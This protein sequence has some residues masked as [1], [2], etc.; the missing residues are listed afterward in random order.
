MPRQR[1]EAEVNLRR[2]GGGIAFQNGAV[3][4]HRIAEDMGMHPG[5]R[6][7]RNY[8]DSGD[9]PAEQLLPS[10][11][12][13]QENSRARRHGR[14]DSDNGQVLKMICYKRKTKKANIEKTEERKQGRDKEKKACQ[15]GTPTR[16]QLPCDSRD[17]KCCNQKKVLQPVAGIH[18]PARV[19]ER[20]VGWPEDLREI[21]AESPSS[22]E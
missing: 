18:F 3:T 19:H 21:E 17:E 13:V 8:N 9:S 16:S 5:K 4:G 1:I 15:R 20:K 22:H 2:P 11:R 10:A 6:G 14:D 12:V 7:Q